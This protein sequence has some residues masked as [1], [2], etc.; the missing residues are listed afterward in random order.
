MINKFISFW[1]RQGRSGQSLVETALFLPLIIL[2]LAGAV[3]VSNLLVTQNRVTTASRVGTGFAAANLRGE[4][5]LSLDPL[6]GWPAQVAAVSRNNVTETLDLDPARWDIYTV[7]ARLSRNGDF[8]PATGGA[9]SSYHAWGDEQT[10]SLAAWSGAEERIKQDIIE[11]LDDTSVVPSEGLELV[12]TVAYHDR[13]SVLGLNAYNLG[14]FTRVRGL[15]VMRVLRRLPADT[16]RR[17][18]RPILDVPL[19]LAHRRP[20]HPLSLPPRR[21][22]DVPGRPRRRSPDFSQSQ[23]DDFP[24]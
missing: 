10:Y 13:N 14:A 22:A 12:A 4:D 18:L 5:W 8:D 7:K 15:T 16:D 9:W 20:G 21:L 6:T 24:R 11:A 2:L 19:K 17:P 1:Q 23:P 3:E